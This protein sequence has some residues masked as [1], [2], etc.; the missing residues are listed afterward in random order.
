MLLTLAMRVCPLAAVRF[1]KL[2]RRPHLLVQHLK[3]H[4]E[5]T[6]PLLVLIV[7]RYCLL[8]RV[9]ATG[10]STVKTS[11]KELKRVWQ[12]LGA[13]TQA[14]W[15]EEEQQLQRTGEATER[16]KEMAQQARHLLHRT[17]IC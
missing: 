8:S 17:S 9:L 11:V 3:Q 14:A 2:Q 13:Q 4:C 5:R 1:A 10:D 12:A 7:R 15:A 16:E 6:L